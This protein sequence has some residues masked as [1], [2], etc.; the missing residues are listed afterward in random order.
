MLHARSSTLI[1]ALVGLVSVPAAG[2]AAPA[3]QEPKDVNLV[4]VGTNVVV[5]VTGAVTAT[6]PGTVT[7][8]VPGRVEVTGTVELAKP[9]TIKSP[10]PFQTGAVG[11][12]GDGNPNLLLILQIPEGTCLRI[13]QVFAEVTLPA[14]SEQ[15]VRAR[16]NTYFVNPGLPNGDFVT[17][18]LHGEEHGNDAFGDYYRISQQLTMYADSLAW[19]HPNDIEIL[20]YRTSAVGP[21]N[22]LATV[23]GALIECP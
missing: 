8:E 22:A 9:I 14:G 2:A 3:T 5:P 20:F 6:V 19:H 15:S 16:M 11:H 4:Q 1:A 21:W 13:D 10:T 18:M 12:A 23:V 7:V 17:A